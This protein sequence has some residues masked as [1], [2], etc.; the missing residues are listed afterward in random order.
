[1]ENKACAS[2]K[3]LQDPLKGKLIAGLLRRVSKK[4]AGLL[5][6]AEG[7]NA[8]GPQALINR[9]PSVILTGTAGQRKPPATPFTGD[10][11]P[12]L[13]RGGTE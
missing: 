4:V 5:C 13:V 11:H 10:S 8:G 1:M 2:G 3:C 7:G 9:S 12:V 6:D